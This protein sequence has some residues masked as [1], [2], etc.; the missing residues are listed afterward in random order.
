MVSDYI[1]GGLNQNDQ[2]LM[3]QHLRDCM[4]CEQ[5]VKRVKNLIRQLRTLPKLT[6]SPDFETILR[7][8][9]S[10]ERHRRERWFAFGEFRIPAFGFA[11]LVIVLVV[12]AALAFRHPNKSITI[13]GKMNKEWYQ[14]GVEK[15]D[16]A[17]NQRYI[18]IYETQPVAR[19]NFQA[20]AEPNRTFGQAAYLDSAQA[21]KSDLLWYKTA[22]ILKTKVY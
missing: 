8:R 7:A 22:E 21:V 16:P 17:T 12:L 15:I 5:S 10:L 4:G 14:A 11:A 1:E 13:Q 9:I 20:P 3:E 2:L 19:I 6:V 18:F